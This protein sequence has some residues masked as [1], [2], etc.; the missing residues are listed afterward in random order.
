MRLKNS[1]K[2]PPYGWVFWY[3]APDGT[4]V[5]LAPQV[6]SLSAL[7]AY[8]IKTFENQG[9]AVPENMQEIV[10]HQICMRQDNPTETCWSGGIGDDLHHKWVK[11][12]LKK[13]IAAV[14]E[15]PETGATPKKKGVLSR[16]FSA[17]RRAV[18]KQAQAI[19]SCVGCSGTITYDPTVNNLGR[20]G[21]LNELPQKLKKIK[22]S[23]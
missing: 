17:A 16:A 4:T 6:N 5:Q 2:T 13:V 20:A 14:E 15:E 3:K 19:K 10:E 23:L 8:V 7:T 1:N 18:R 22:P 21:V 12:F 11:P 9:I